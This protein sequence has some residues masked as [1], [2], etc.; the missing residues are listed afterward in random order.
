MQ[1]KSKKNSKRSIYEVIVPGPGSYNPQLLKNTKDIWSFKPI[2]NKRNTIF[3]E[4]SVNFSAISKTTNQSSNKNESINQTDKFQKNL[5]Q[6]TK[7]KIKNRF[8]SKVNRF[9]DGIFE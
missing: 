7:G 8:D 5:D 4:N 9:I 1:R 2:R 3:T 6:F